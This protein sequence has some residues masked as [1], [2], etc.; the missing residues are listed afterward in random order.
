MKKIFALMVAV[1]FGFGAIG[2]DDKAKTTTPSKGS[3]PSM[4]PGMTKGG[5][6]KEDPKKEEMK[7]DEP[8][9][10]E[11]KKDEPKKDEPKN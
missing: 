4:P 10:D 2:C 8:K 1:A 9:K 7:K 3:V 6:K 5:D 11:P